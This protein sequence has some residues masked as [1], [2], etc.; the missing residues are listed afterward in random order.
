[1][2]RLLLVAAAAAVGLLV[3]AQ[4]VAAEFTENTVGCQG[5]AT[6]RGK[7]GKTYLVDA[8]DKTVK[9][10]REGTANWAG[11][12]TTTT[13]DHSGVV[14]LKLGPLNITLGKWGPSKNAN[15]ENAKAGVKDIP[16]AVKWVP[17]GKYEVNGHHQ[18]KEGRCAG[19][20]TVELEGNPLGTPV[21]AG[22]AAGTVLTGLG[23]V[24]SGMARKGAA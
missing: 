13:H 5:R 16:E 24:V 15:N 21:G 18:G 10:P 8:R 20:V 7:D 11:A 19:K 12:V 23:L 9:A 4:P 3:C 14:R 22:V 17:P 1:M 6:V 2:R